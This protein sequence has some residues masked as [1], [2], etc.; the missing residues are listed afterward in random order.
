MQDFENCG[1]LMNS[2]WGMQGLII[3][4]LC[5]VTVY[6]TGCHSEFMEVVRTLVA[7]RL[8]RRSTQ[9]IEEVYIYIYIIG[10]AIIVIY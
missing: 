6:F 4:G 3:L 1:V 2:I 8:L 5:G 9:D 10:R 7:L